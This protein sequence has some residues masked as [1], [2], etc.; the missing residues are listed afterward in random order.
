MGH[1]GTLVT[2]RRTEERSSC[3]GSTCFGR[4][5]QAG[6]VEAFFVVTAG[7]LTVT[8]GWETRSPAGSAYAAVLLLEV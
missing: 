3:G 5:C 2:R 1:S 8:I 4:L 6:Y 7:G